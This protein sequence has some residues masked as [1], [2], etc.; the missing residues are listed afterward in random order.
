VAQGV[1]VEITTPL[2]EAIDLRSTAAPAAD[3]ALALSDQHP[4]YPTRF[5]EQL[6]PGG[7]Q[8]PPVRNRISKHKPWT[9]PS[10]EDRYSG[11]VDNLGSQA[12]STQ[13]SRQL[14]R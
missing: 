6:S 7:E 13:F 10:R 2:R 4:R 1:G 12:G 9:H 8:V 3:R 11:V 5:S 14:T